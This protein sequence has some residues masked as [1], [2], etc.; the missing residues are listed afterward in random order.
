M[1]DCFFSKQRLSVSCL[2]VF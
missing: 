1:K 2:F